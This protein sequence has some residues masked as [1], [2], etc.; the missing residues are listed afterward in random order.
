MIM[1][2][3]AKNIYIVIG[4][5][6]LMLLGSCKKWLDVQPEDK[7]TEKQIF[8]T[9]QG[10]SDAL[11][12]IYLDM[13]KSKLYGAT[14]T[15]TILDILAQ[16]YNVSALHT[17]TKY[18]TYTYDDKDV[19]ARLD[20]IWTNAYINVVNANKFIKN[21]DVYPGVLDAQTDSL[22]RGEAY[23]LRAF[24]QFDLLRMYGPVYSTADSLKT[25]IPY[26]TAAG[27][28]VNPILPA[29]EVMQKVITDLK[30]AESLLLADPIRTKGIVK[31]SDKNYLTYRNYRMNYFAVKGLQARAYLYRGDK[32]SAAAAAKEVIDHTTKF[33]W[34]TS[35]NIL[36]DKSNPDRVFS[37]EI[38]FGLQSL[39]LYDNYRAFFAPDLQDK[40]VL[41]PLD[42][43]LKATFENNENDSRYNP[44]WM[45]TGI[46]GKGYKTFFKYADINDKKLIYRLTVP[47]IRLSEVYYIAAES[48]QNVAYLNTVRNNRGLLNLP[49]TASLTTELQKEYQKEFFG[50]GQLWYYYKRRNLSPIP[51]P[52]VASGTITMNATKYVFPLPLSELTPR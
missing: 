9:P 26:Y 31:S 45:L 41:A 49:G 15:G 20:N 10:I 16:R 47:L 38:L 23:A 50:E 48:E 18:Q 24:L 34:I 21:L 19:K 33:P 27:I 44:N 25:A 17:L 52:L 12:G 6:S 28:D 5:S 7:F 8:A 39:D 32:I 22:F 42:S 1:K 4:L 40:D 13:G 11:N 3:L 36:S 37:T 14:L 29:N 30:K 35:G 51:N 43:R 2:R 46:G